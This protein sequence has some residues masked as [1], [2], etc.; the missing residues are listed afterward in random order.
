M[1]AKSCWLQGR[2]GV[3]EIVNSHMAGP[4]V[5]AT[6]GGNGLVSC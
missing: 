4:M 3:E 6:V 5:I 1:Q 2:D